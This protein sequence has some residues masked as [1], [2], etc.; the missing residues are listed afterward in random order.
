MIFKT[1]QKPKTVPQEPCELF[2]VE[3]CYAQAGHKF[4][5]QVMK[6]STFIPVNAK[7]YFKFGEVATILRRNGRYFL[8]RN[9]E[10]ENELLDLN[11]SKSWVLV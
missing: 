11:D 6:M 4:P 9:N 3:E 2:T 1:E 5:F 8:T 7:H 10:D